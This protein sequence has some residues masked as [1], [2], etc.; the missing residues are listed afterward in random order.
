LR[1]FSALPLFF[2][3]QSQRLK[4][5]DEL[6]LGLEV[7]GGCGIEFLDLQEHWRPLGSFFINQILGELNYMIVLFFISTNCTEILVNI[8]TG[9]LYA[10]V[11]TWFIFLATFTDR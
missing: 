7:S 5:L 11:E 6:S 1:L 9:R 4:V 2:G 8:R 10:E 3:A